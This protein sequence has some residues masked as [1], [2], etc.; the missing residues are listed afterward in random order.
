MDDEGET[1]YSGSPSP[2][3]QLPN[4]C[5]EDLHLRLAEL[6]DEKHR[7]ELRLQAK[8]NEILRERIARLEAEAQ[9]NQSDRN[10]KLV[11]QHNNCLLLENHELTLQIG[12]LQRQ[13]E[14][15]TLTRSAS[16]HGIFMTTPV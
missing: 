5:M 16:K 15:S 4:Q 6:E 1:K 13:L 10:Y 3:L 7:L 9:V 8:E 14:I 11:E 12:R 2:Y